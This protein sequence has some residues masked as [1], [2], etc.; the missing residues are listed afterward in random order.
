MVDICLR[1]ELQWCK[2]IAE[3]PTTEIPRTPCP[4]RRGVCGGRWLRDST[5][6]SQ[7]NEPVFSLETPATA[8]PSAR[9]SPTV[10]SKW[11][12]APTK[13]SSSTTSSRGG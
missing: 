8:K 11:P 7:V 3:T 12:T 13:P 6:G 10:A 4:S 2:H 5:G 9:A 1:L